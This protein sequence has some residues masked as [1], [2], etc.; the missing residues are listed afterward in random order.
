MKRKTFSVLFFIKRG[1]LL[2][3]G[4]APIYCRVTVNSERIEFATKHSVDPN[5]WNARKGCARGGKYAKNINLFLQER[6]YKIYEYYHELEKSGRT[7]TAKRLVAVLNGNSTEEKYLLRLYQEHNENLEKLIDKGFSKLTY[8]RHCTSKSHLT[9]FL[10]SKYKLRDI[11]LNEINPKFIGDYEVYLRTERNCNNNTTVKYIKN[12]K[13]IVNIGIVNGWV[14]NNPFTGIRFRYERTNKTFLSPDELKRISSKEIA[15][16]RLKLVRDIF[17]FCCYTGLSFIDIKNLQKSDIVDGVDGKKWIIKKRKKTSQEFTVPLIP[18]SMVI[19]NEYK[20]N[21]YCEKTNYVLP[22]ISNQRMNAYLKEI[23][24]ICGIQKNL[25]THTGRHTFATTVTLSNK[26]S[27]EAVSK[28]LGHSS[29]EM[30]KQY[31][32]ITEHF[33]SSEMAKLPAMSG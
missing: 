14:K 26:I 10:E 28:M 3:N 1:K 2:K 13:K 23:A 31:A 6:R 29:L 15:I 27:M 9:D 30:T 4:E 16:P 20:D 19:L 7:L 33:I 25:T 5:N 22:I 17:L 18:E 24:D 11:A 12:F 32:R 21:P 8:L